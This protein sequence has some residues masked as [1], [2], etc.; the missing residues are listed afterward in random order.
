MP[1]TVVK[2]LDRFLSELGLRGSL[3]VSFPDGKT[4]TYGDGAGDR[5]HVRIHNWNALWRIALA[6]DP[7]VAEAFMD[8]DLTFDEGDVAALLKIAYSGPQPAPGTERH[9]ILPV[10][11]INFL[12]RRLHQFNPKWRSRENVQHHYDLS[13]T[14]Y[15]LFL[16]A[17]R[18]YSCAYYPQPGMTL[19]D[20]QAAKKHHIAAKMLLEPGMRILDIGRAGAVSASRWRGNT[21]R[22]FRA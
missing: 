15:D 12:M 16:D 4:R 22:R 5:V 20:A 3:L 14:L 2:L 13:R 17:D 11:K 1:S 21:A 8:G 19:D 9:P 10:D 6:P 18:Q 7:G